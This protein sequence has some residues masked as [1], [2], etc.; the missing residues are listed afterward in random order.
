[1]NFYLAKRFVGAVR[2]LTGLKE[3]RGGGGRVA[4][5]NYHRRRLS[6]RRSLRLL[7][8]DLSKKKKDSSI[9]S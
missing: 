7:T 4:P 6:V 3:E 1:L 5:E 9:K 8:I 2:L